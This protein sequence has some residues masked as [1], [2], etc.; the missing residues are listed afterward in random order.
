MVLQNVII[1]N[2]SVSGGPGDVPVENVS[3][4]YG[5]VTYT[6]I[7]PKGGQPASQVRPPKEP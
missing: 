3:L 7:D 1:A 4:D 6:Y 2:F 5:S